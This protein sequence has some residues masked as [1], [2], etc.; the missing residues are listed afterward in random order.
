VNLLVKNNHECYSSIINTVR[1]LQSPN[2]AFTLREHYE[3]TQ[4]QVR[5]MNNSTLTGE[6]T[7]WD[8]EEGAGVAWDTTAR[9]TQDG[10]YTVQ[11]V[12]FDET[13][14][15]SD[16]AAVVYDMMFKTLFVPNAFSPDNAA[17]GVREFKPIG[18]NLSS[19]TLQIFDLG[20]NK[21]FETSELDVKGR[22]ARGWDG[23]YKG[24]PLPMGTFLWK[25]S[26][27]FRDGTIW[28]GKVVGRDQDNPGANH[29]SLILIR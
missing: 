22:P 3:N 1:T 4:G 8:W 27:T 24:T 14:Q 28:N 16:T 6:Y 29:G 25:I 10:M 19:Y 12:V 20:G 23:T 7:Y 13:E 2:A 26:A 11:L 17:Q 21:M 15:C 9:F 18:R 5:L